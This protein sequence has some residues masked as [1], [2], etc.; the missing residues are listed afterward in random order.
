MLGAAN[1]W[2]HERFLIKK[3]ARGRRADA[4]SNL[5]WEKIAD[6]KAGAG[7]SG[8]LAAASRSSAKGPTRTTLTDQ[9]PELIG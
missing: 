2:V 4:V 3:A 6:A 9:E 1:V 7:G 8:R 5:L